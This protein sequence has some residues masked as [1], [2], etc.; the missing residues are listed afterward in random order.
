MQPRDIYYVHNTPLAGLAAHLHTG[1]AGRGRTELLERL[2]FLDLPEHLERA[3]TDKRGRAVYGLWTRKADPELIGRL[4]EGFL[5][6]NGRSAD[7]YEIRIAP[8]RG[9]FMLTAFLFRCG[10]YRAARFFLARRGRLS[11]EHLAPAPGID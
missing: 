6:L 7:G 11:L 4:V 5:F 9:R 10:F 1:R 8:G 2:P 3:G